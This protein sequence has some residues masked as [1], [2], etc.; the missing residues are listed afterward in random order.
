MYV[1]QRC[2]HCSERYSYFGADSTHLL[3]GNR[4]TIVYVSAQIFPHGGFAVEHDSILLPFV[5]ERQHDHCLHTSTDDTSD[6]EPERENACIHQEQPPVRKC[7]YG[8]QH[9]DNLLPGMSI[10]TDYFII[11][12][13]GIDL[14]SPFTCEEEYRFIHWCVKHSLN[15]AGINKLFWNR[16]MATGRSCTLSSDGK[17]SKPAVRFRVRVGTKLEPLQHVVPDQK[18]KPDRPHGFLASSSILPT[19]NFGSN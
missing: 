19:P 6:T 14:W 9:Q 10:I 7:I 12:E 4:E 17:S 1:R 15:R 2:L 11:F 18:T 13:V 5:Y 8:T 16:R 3:C